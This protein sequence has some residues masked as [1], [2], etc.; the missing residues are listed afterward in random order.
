MRLPSP[1]ALTISSVINTGDLG[2]AT[3][4]GLNEAHFAGYQAEW[5]FLQRYQQSYS[6]HLP[7]VDVLTS[8]FPDFPHRSSA[9]ETAF[10]A[11]QVIERANGRMVRAALLSSTDLVSAGDLSGAI[12]AVAS[13][14]LTASTTACVDAVRST[15][16]LDEIGAERQHCVPYPW[17]T[18]H[19]LTGGMWPGDYA[20]YAARSTVG[21]S[22]ALLYSAADAV[23]GGNHVVYYSLEMPVPQIVA[24]V[25]VIIG[26]KLGIVI[27]HKS[28]HERTVDRM[29]Y[30]KLLERM[31]E[32]VPGRLDVVDTSSGRITPAS[33]ASRPEADL[34]I[35]DHLGLMSTGQGSRA[36]EDWR[37]MAS[38]SNQ[39]KETAIAAN[40]PVLSAAQ[41]NREG[42]R[43]SSLPGLSDLA[44]SDAIG[45]DAD[46]VMS[47]RRMGNAPVMR[48]SVPKNRHG[49]VGHGF[50][51]EFFPDVGRMREI[52]KERAEDLC[53]DD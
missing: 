25:H 41:V 26:Q 16:I 27:S 52:D 29:L 32:Q 23:M 48:Y 47:M 53:D 17:P 4:R 18:L 36:I 49:D 33:V 24:R 31:E 35:V 40:K 22:W 34:V 5:A 19:S 51:S 3:S 21:K 10:Y 46:M 39:L 38:I 44:Q 50:Y 6:G 7:S 42:A 11:D 1:E 14:R 15:V 30:K 28:L 12:N 37:V 8:T 20:V 9:T 2:A 45:Q 13:V 43:G